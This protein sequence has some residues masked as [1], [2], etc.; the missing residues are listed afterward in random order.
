VTIA[1][2]IEH[3]L[4]AAFVPTELAVHNES[5]QHS[6]PRGSETHFKVVIVS[7][8][9]A[10]KLPVARHQLVYGVLAEELRSGVH[11]LTITSRTPEE[12]SASSAV[13]ASPRCLGGSSAES[14][15]TKAETKPGH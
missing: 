2:R 4:R 9:F 12:W 3:K 13:S 5:D 10:N 1:E 8:A 11:A 7:S 15:G 6:V 14:V